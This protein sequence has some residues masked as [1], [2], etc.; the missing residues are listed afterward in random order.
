[1]RLIPCPITVPEDPI[2]L[3]VKTNSNVT[4]AFESPDGSVPVEVMSV[5]DPSLIL[6]VDEG[7]AVSEM[8]PCDLTLMVLPTTAKLA[9]K[10]EDPTPVPS[11]EVSIVEFATVTVEVPT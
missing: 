8:N 11:I 7:V 3:N 10:I 1:M 6:I 4:S 5:T 2:D 9:G